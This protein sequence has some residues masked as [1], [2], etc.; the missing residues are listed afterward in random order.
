MFLFLADFNLF[1]FLAAI[2]E[3]GLFRPRVVAA[4]CCQ[5]FLVVSF[6]LLTLVYLSKVSLPSIWVQQFLTTDLSL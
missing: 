2:L 4:C 6:A 3:K 5:F 1:E